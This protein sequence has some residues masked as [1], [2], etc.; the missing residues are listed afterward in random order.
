MLNNGF[1]EVWRSDKIFDK[2]LFILW[3]RMISF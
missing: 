1:K 3:L 2:A